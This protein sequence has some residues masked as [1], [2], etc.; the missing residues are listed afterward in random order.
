MMVIFVSRSEG[1]AIQTVRRILDSFALRIGTDTWKTVITEEG[2][3][4]VR[5]LLRRNA[6]KNTAVACHWIRSRSRSELVW[7]VGKR[8][9]FNA[10]GVVPVHATSKNI[11]HREW[12][13]DWQYLGI[14]KAAAAL[15]ALLHDWGKASDLFQKKLKA[16][17]KDGIKADPFRHEWI[18]CKLLEALVRYTGSLEDDKPWLSALAEGAI[19]PDALVSLAAENKAALG[20][21][22]PIAGLLAWGSYYRTTGCRHWK[23]KNVIHMQKARLLPSSMSWNSSAHPGDTAAMMTPRCCR[24]VFPFGRAY[25][26]IRG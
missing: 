3:Q 24:H 10:E 8:D 13:N 25:C 1:K 5:T 18:S 26:G 2:L 23:N 16:A 11:A 4:T 22:P 12:E 9:S 7:V 21:M 19:E 17:G 14:I 6:T 15:A 20:P